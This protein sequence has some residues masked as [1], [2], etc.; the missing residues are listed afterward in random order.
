MSCLNFQH[1]PY[2]PVHTHNMFI[3][4]N[5][6][7]WLD[8]DAT[9]YCTGCYILW[10]FT[11]HYYNIMHKRISIIH[12]NAVITIHNHHHSWRRRRRHRH[13]FNTTHILFMIFL[14]HLNF[15]LSSSSSTSTTHGCC[16]CCVTNCSSV[17]YNANLHVSTKFA[18]WINYHRSP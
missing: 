1:F 17:L 11:L 3:L 4:L 18:H 7:T 12:R 14:L 8:V 2:S 9:M 5:Y 6:L 13:R 15:S 16:C 10:I